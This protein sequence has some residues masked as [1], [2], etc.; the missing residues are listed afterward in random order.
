MNKKED[1]IAGD[2]EQP[3]FDFRIP[4]TSLGSCI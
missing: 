3:K 2:W 4:P 1:I